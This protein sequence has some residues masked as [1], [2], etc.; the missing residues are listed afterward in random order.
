MAG[1]PAYQERSAMI[2]QAAAALAATRIIG[3]GQRV[4]RS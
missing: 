4:Y 1:D 2:V 3:A